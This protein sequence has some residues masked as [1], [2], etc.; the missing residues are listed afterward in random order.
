MFLNVSLHYLLS[1]ELVSPGATEVGAAPEAF[2]DSE[3]HRARKTG[4]S[5]PLLMRAWGDLS[6]Y[7]IK[8]QLT[9]L[10]ALRRL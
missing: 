3:R 5:Q 9:L 10:L 4:S 1:F 8:D 7:S 2:S 6:I